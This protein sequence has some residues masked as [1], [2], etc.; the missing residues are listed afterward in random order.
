MVRGAWRA[1]VYQVVKESDTTQ[2]LNSNSKSSVKTAQLQVNES[3][4]S[5]VQINR[6]FFPYIPI[7]KNP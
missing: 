6:D 7:I 4:I 3:S 5:T 2:Q 1:T